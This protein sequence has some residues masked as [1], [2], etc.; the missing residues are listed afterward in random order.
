MKKL[1]I[2]LLLLLPLCSCGKKDTKDE[3]TAT[4]SSS[5]ETNQNQSGVI[6]EGSY[7]NLKIIDYNQTKTKLLYKDT[8]ILV[9][10]QTSCIHCHDYKP[11][12]N[13]VLESKDILGYELDVQVLSQEDKEAALKKLDVDTTPQTLFFVNGVE[14]KEYRLKGE[15]TSKE[16]EDVIKKLKY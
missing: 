4:Y 7:S 13:K 5:E 2:L 12:L 8:F 3:S 10:T 6:K 11:V 14:K 9:V 1:L 16:I 15:A